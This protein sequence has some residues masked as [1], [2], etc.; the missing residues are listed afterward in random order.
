MSHKI[1]NMKQHAFNQTRP[2]TQFRRTH[3]NKPWKPN[4]QVNLLAFSRRSRQQ[5]NKHAIS[6]TKLL[7]GRVILRWDRTTIHN[8]FRVYEGFSKKLVARIR[9]VFIF[10]SYAF[11]HFT[12]VKTC[13]TRDDKEKIEGRF[14][15]NSK[16]KCTR[17]LVR[18]YYFC[19]SE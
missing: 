9:F 5:L 7:T 1:H 12:H 2:S 8:K 6:P 10:S 3:E 19:N 18:Q 13:F 17:F 14:I 4:R 15:T 16:E 11:S